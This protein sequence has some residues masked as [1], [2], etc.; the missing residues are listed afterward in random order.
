MQKP[1]LRNDPELSAREEV[2]SGGGETGALM[3]AFDWSKTSLGPV[4]SW[5]Q[6][7]KTCVR[8]VL[9]SRQPMFVWWG[10]DLINLYNDAYKSILGGK[11]PQALG[12]PAKLVWREI[13]DQVGPRAETAMRSN[14]GTYDEA[15]L[16]IMERYGY[17]EETYYTFSYSPVPN[18][19][20]GTGG[21]ICAN[22][23]DTQRII[24]ERQLTSMRELSFRTADAR[25]WEDVCRLSAESLSTNP[26]DICFAVLY[27]LDDNK[28]HLRLAGRS[29]ISVGHPA[30]PESILVSDDS[31]WPLAE[32]IRSHQL[33]LVRNVGNR[34]L[35][36]PTGAWDTPPSTVAVVPIASSGP[37]GRAGVAV[38]GLNPYRLPDDNYCG[39]LRLL[40]GQISASIAN[41]E[42]YEQERRRAES[43]AELDRAKTTFFSN[44]S[45][46]FRTPL[47]L[48]LGPLED[49]LAQ[50][51]QSLG[52][53]NSERLETVHRNG[54]RL[55]K[56]VNSLLDFSR[57]E[58]GRVQASYEAIDI[59]NLTAELASVF[60]AAIEK[61]G[62]RL[63]VEC[64]SVEG[65]VYVDRD[66]W[67][68]IVLN[69][70][71]NAFKFTFEG[72]ITVA[73]RDLGSEI[74]LSIRDTG[75]GIPEHELP[76]LFERFH[77]VEGAKGR[78]FE[79]S[80]IG[81][82]LVQELVKL[83]CGNIRVESKVA[84][85][86]TFFITIPKG[87]AHLPGE[88][89]NAKRTSSTGLRAE[90]YV[91]EALHWLPGNPSTYRNA[92][93]A[94]EDSAADPSTVVLADDNAD[95]RDY[96]RNLLSSDHRVLVAENGVKALE[97]VR[98]YNPDLVL[99][100]VM[101]PVLD[102]FGLLKEIRSDDSISSIPVVMLS[103]RA[104]EEARVEG[105]NAGADDYLVKPFTARELLARV[106][107]Q[108]SITR[109]RRAAE[110]NERRLRAEAE[111]ERQKL[112]DLFDQ[113]PAAIC[114]L[115][116]PSHVW[117][118][119]NPRYLQIVGRR[120]PGE[121]LNRCVRETLP[122]IESQ[123]FLD[124]LHSVYRSGKTYVGLEQEVRLVEPE[125]KSRTWYLDFVY[126]PMRNADGAVEGILVHA[127]DVTD[128]V[129]ARQ[130]VERREQLLQAALTASST[131][132]FRWD[133]ATDKF[134]HF[135]DSLKALFGIPL[136]ETVVHAEQ[137]LER[138]HPDD[139][140]KVAAA[141]DRSR[142][143]ADFEMEYRVLLPGGR[144]RWLYDRAKML[145]DAT[146]GLQMIGACT[147]ITSARELTEQLRALN[148]IGQQIS[149]ELDQ[150]KLLQLITDV[151]TKGTGA[152]FGAFFYNID[153]GQGGRYMLSTISGV[154]RSNFDNFPMPRNTA[155]FAATF[156]G[157]PTVRSADIRKDTRLGHTAPY[158]GTPP[159]HLPVVS[160]LAV[161]VKGKE[162]H[163]IGGLFF[164]HQQEGVFSEQHE[165]F[166]E[167]VA[168]QA[169]VALE[170]ASLYETAMRELHHRSEVEA[171]LE[172]QRRFLAL[173]QKSANVGSWQLD[174]SSPERRVTWSEE[175]EILYGREPGSMG[176][177]FENWQTTVHPD[178]LP[179]VLRLVESAIQNHDQLVTEFRIVRPDGTTRW[180]AARGQCFYD[181]VGKPVKLLGVNIDITER[182]IAEDALRNSEKLAATGRLAATIAHEINNPL[183]AVMNLI[184]LAQRHELSPAVRNYLEQAD[185]ELE[186]VSHIA[187]QT[188]GFY[189]DTSSPT[190]VNAAESL[191]DVLKI[192]ER[193]IKYKSLTL[194]VSIPEKL[195]IRG[196][197]GEVRQIL[198]NLIAN[199]IEA[200]AK[201]GTIHVRARYVQNR[202]STPA[203][204]ILVADT[205][206]GIPR[207]MKE[208]IFTP[209][210]STKKDVGTGLGLWVTKSMVEKHQGTI[211]F[212]SKE[213]LGTVFML[214][215]PVYSER[216][217]QT[218]ATA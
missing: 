55:L 142:A 159:G 31:V 109:A 107:A 14:E 162:G 28:E 124:L 24:S 194:N 143:G 183:E 127:V 86:T 33:E 100:D 77:R 181:S 138:V 92:E 119:A 206:H 51:R 144:V 72:S 210:F 13:W 215:F 5:P 3:R 212:R 38:I 112:Q 140:T 20:G 32:A 16:L 57:I 30:A 125:G 45:H 95:M 177:T 111:A 148:Q 199:A 158:Y 130:E 27:V 40:A 106:N 104:G 217:E 137:F 78:S 87:K 205:G 204:R 214:M 8:I 19:Q 103:A 37:T 155:L 114:V 164:G 121:I 62:M 93:R 46:E 117:T 115:S 208:R 54:L 102:G 154:P 60:R 150:Q 174:L 75:T 132:T 195:A 82:A 207:A 196:L 108:V 133:P 70:L 58:A 200:C 163:V 135:D 187:Q 209:F 79:G 113:T 116:G 213:G 43:L 153:D 22:T 59:C 9:T 15:L 180:M 193:K 168:A 7:L 63:D 203:I 68:K 184:F 123:G 35:S 44:V 156:E 2:L 128:K 21:I 99:T 129:H 48:M 136:A 61:A 4:A 80:G 160:Y 218:R 105:L 190:T 67:E 110:E 25:T 66:M 47:T 26:K 176:H 198:S 149:A 1:L 6:N 151:A 39:F 182:R 41:A 96:V 145:L 88:R 10:D 120:E 71:S 179:D 185:G 134:S 118:Y 171:K 73:V 147:D 157:G 173:A 192:F 189:R 36:L 186:R 172:E 202:L 81:L 161:P 122:E 65:D 42:A 52:D 34:F 74:E 178:D 131:G 12:Q 175:L 146:G 17:P 211:R 69:L 76:R 216:F 201:N 165:R 64:D 11:H 89:I 197:K 18:D 139:R 83:H 29:G 191:S 126:Q 152:Q 169:G 101:M 50:G 49:T 167:A 23:D 98:N 97:L 166:V 53:E 90:A 141:V 170:N 85:G 94:M 84:V 56:L 188:L 91:D